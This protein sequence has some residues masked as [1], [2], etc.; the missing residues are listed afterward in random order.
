[1]YLG[2]PF[3]H[4]ST[5]VQAFHFRVCHFCILRLHRSSC[6]A[7]LEGYAL[8]PQLKLQTPAAC[9]KPYRAVQTQA[10]KSVIEASSLCVCSIP[11]LLLDTSHT[12][13]HQLHALDFALES[14]VRFWLACCT[15]RIL[16]ACLLSYHGLRVLFLRE[17]SLLLSACQCDTKSKSDMHCSHSFF[18]FI[19]I[20]FSGHSSMSIW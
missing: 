17:G 18:R 8:H 6:R 14:L 3:L 15:L 16:S 7:V 9:Q 12:K 10:F 13:Q 2:G 11:V 20:A 1:M 19:T 5:A 4:A